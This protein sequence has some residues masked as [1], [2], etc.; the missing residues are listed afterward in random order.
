MEPPKSSPPILQPATPEVYNFR[1]SATRDF[2]DKFERLAEVVGVANAQK[3]M[4][5]ILEKALDIALD[6]K[7]PKK[8]LERRRKR[9]EKASKPSRSERDGE[10]D[11]HAESRYVA[12]EV[13][14]RVHERDGYQCLYSSGRKF[15]K[16]ANPGPR[17]APWNQLTTRRRSRTRSSVFHDRWQPPWAIRA[18]NVRE[19]QV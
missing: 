11:E 18:R 14:A 2:K 15:V 13:S 17:D 6:K 1:F 8:K 4:A 16:G 12:S 7:D 9:Q 3:N 5:E 19:R 10:K